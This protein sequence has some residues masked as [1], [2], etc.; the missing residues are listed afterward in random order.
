MTSNQ[1]TPHHRP[2][3]HPHINTNTS[4]HQSPARSELSQRLQ[5]NPQLNLNQSLIQPDLNSMPN[6]IKERIVYWVDTLDHH[7]LHQ[8]IHQSTTT[9]SNQDD[10][11]QF[12]DLD[13]HSSS[14]SASSSSSNKPSKSPLSSIK[15]LSLV[16][17]T[18]YELCRPL[19][20]EVSPLLF[21]STNTHTS[22]PI[23]LT[24]FSVT[25]F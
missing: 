20:W 1:K 3:V 22:H 23:T 19:I 13:Q 17:R 14:S 11:D 24:T 8:S 15:S 12:E 10:D 2:S 9:I 16:D 25:R 5:S 7:P 21:L 18:F 4:L 6:E